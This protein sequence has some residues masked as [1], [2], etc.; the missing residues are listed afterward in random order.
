MHSSVL[1]YIL[2]KHAI[3]L[4]RRELAY[5]E[6]KFLGSFS[7]CCANVLLARVFFFK[8]YNSTSQ[9]QLEAG[10]G[11]LPSLLESSHLILLHVWVQASPRM[12]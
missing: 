11:L 7:G 9:L 1:P 10:S 2:K 8:L 5:L 12:P 3:L 6:E 4:A